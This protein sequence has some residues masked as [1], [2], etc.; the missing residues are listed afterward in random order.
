MTMSVSITCLAWR[1]ATP[2]LQPLGLVC[3]LWLL[4]A[5]P[6]GAADYLDG[7]WFIISGK[8]KLST[9]IPDHALLK[10]SARWVKDGAEVRILA[11][12]SAS[13]SFVRLTNGAWW[14]NNLPES[15]WNK[16]VEVN[17]AN[18]DIQAVALTARGGWAM[19][20][21]KAELTTEGVHEATRAALQAAI[22]EL[23]QAGKAGQPRFLAFAPDGGWLILAARDY[24]EHG[25]PPELSQHLA[26]HKRKG[27]PVRC[28]AFDSRG[29]WFLLDDH[30]DC[31]SSNP[32]H[33]AFQKL[34]SLQAAGEQLRL[35]TFTPGV[36]AH[37]YVLEHRPV[38]R[39]EVQ[40]SLAFRGPGAR[41]ERWAVFPPAFP[42]LPR[43]R[44]VKVHL[45][46]A[47]TPVADDGLLAQK[48]RIIRARG[49]PDAFEVR[50]RAELTL[51]T[52]R[53]LPRLAEQAPARVELSPGQ[54]R[55]F[56]H[57][58]DDMKTPV[59]KEFV[60]KEHLHRGPTESDLDFARRV[61]LHVSKH[62]T[63]IYPN[64]EG[65]DVIQC[66]KGD[67]GGL[68]WVFVRVLRAGGVPARLLLGH[69]AESE[70]PGQHGQ[71]PD[72]QCH[73][74]AEFFAEGV[75]W[76]DADLAGGVGAPG[77]PLVCFGNEPGDFV[78]SDLDIDRLVR[79][80]PDDRPSRLGGT[81]GF[82]WWYQ[83]DAGKGIRTEGH[84]TVKTL[85]PH[86]EQ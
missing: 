27:I 49:K 66:G 70:K 41:V 68:S 19:L 85:D 10:D 74:K 18:H 7:D 25:L 42:E 21:G 38:R 3:C 44:A 29:D 12:P 63:Y 72:T 22:D 48:A 33:A 34:K 13:A 71:G 11:L 54:A 37:G 23:K 73:V 47:G 61:F 79:V 4:A 8:S 35:I 9:S 51:Y 75:G 28:V 46:P 40:M 59:F 5:A 20:S 30:N 14:G 69:W 24:R 17:K 32:E 65:K 52:N 58:T 43:Q 81:Q 83:G 56:T 6:A 64:I 15:L 26:A 57:V 31:F 77:N 36:Y 67:C 84:W 86:P 55:V 16:N 39:V 76:V 45:E 82:F 50:L 60:D 78:V 53:L 80:W 62:F 2:S 1:G